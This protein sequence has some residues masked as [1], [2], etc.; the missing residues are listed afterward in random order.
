MQ[1]SP[2][3]DSTTQGFTGKAQNARSK[4]GSGILLF[5]FFL[6]FFFVSFFGSDADVLLQ[7]HGNPVLEALLKAVSLFA[8]FLIGSFIAIMASENMQPS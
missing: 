4:Y 2:R 6:S 3:R 1:N 7:Y 5:S 8:I